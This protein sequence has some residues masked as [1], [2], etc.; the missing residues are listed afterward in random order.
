MNP[1][2]LACSFG[3]ITGI[4]WWTQDSNKL[5]AMGMLS[6]SLAAAVTTIVSSL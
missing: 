4:R 3:V 5:P 1:I 2:L 6:L